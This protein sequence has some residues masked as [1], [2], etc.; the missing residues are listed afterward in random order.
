M[1]ILG[2]K[3]LSAVISIILNFVWWIEWAFAAVF[4]IMMWIS[5]HIR[6]ECVLPL[7][8]TFSE[9]T[10]GT[11]Q[12]INKTFPGGHI[13]TTNGILS[14]QV[15]ANIINVVLLAIGYGF[16]FALISIITY[17]LKMIFSNFKKHLPFNTLNIYRI[18]NIAIVL[19]AY[20]V[21]QWLYVVLVNT[22][23]NSQIKWR[24]MELSY[25]FNVNYALMG[26]ILI[27]VAGIFQIGL[28]LEEEKQLTI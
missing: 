28:S 23:L 6:G 10:I 26:V 5:I 14:L 7:P 19:I 2:N 3:S 13:N 20:S 8:V 17:Q 1:K 12:S 18:R 21:V 24:H 15:Q 9:I 4:I 11:V 25:S 22:I 27:I 16:I